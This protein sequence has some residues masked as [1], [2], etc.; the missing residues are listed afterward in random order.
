MAEAEEDSGKIPP[1]SDDKYWIAASRPLL[2]RLADE[3]LTRK[4]LWK[5]CKFCK[6]PVKT[7]EQCLDW[8]SLKGLVVQVTRED[9]HKAYIRAS[10]PSAAL[11][12][13]AY[14]V[15][16]ASLPPEE[17]L[18]ETVVK[19]WA[20]PLVA[21]KSPAPSPSP[22]LQRKA[23]AARLAAARFAK[24]KEEAVEDDEDEDEDLDDA[25]DVDEDDGEPEVAAEPELVVEPAPDTSEDEEDPPMV[26]DLMSEVEAAQFL[27]VKKSTVAMMRRKEKI[28]SSKDPETGTVRYSKADLV[29]YMKSLGKAPTRQPV[30]EDDPEEGPAGHPAAPPASSALVVRKRPGKRSPQLERI[31]KVLSCHAENILTPDETLNVILRIVTEDD[32]AKDE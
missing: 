13:P 24:P 31:R 22:A 19:A 32:V 17:P 21:Y 29:K 26:G 2:A 8:L 11:L 1:G 12:E 30:A 20:T 6:K 27:D 18:I 10:H 14:G 15:T 5:W 4:D 9:G 25:E 3:A 28:K 7:M 23:L 16:I